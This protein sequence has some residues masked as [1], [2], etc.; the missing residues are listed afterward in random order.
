MTRNYPLCIDFARL[1]N[2]TNLLVVIFFPLTN[3]VE[4]DVRF[5]LALAPPAPFAKVVFRLLMDVKLPGPVAKK[6]SIMLPPKLIPNGLNM[7]WLS[8]LDG[9]E[10]LF[11]LLRWPWLPWKSITCKQIH[12][13]KNNCHNKWRRNSK[14]PRSESRN[15]Y[16][17]WES[18]SK[19]DLPPKRSANG[20]P[21]KNSLNTSSGSR[22]VKKPNPMSKSSS[23]LLRDLGPPPFMSP[24]LP[25]WSYTLR[26]FSE[27]GER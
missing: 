16:V 22:N 15:V 20:V 26:F 17:A 14:S 7:W 23:C 1:I 11:R 9:C 2:L 12:V 13:N 4:V 18:N 27:N 8:A 21:P 25:Y 6:S 24:S 5:T 19:L 10:F 3:R